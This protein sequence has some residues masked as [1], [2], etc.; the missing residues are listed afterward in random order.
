LKLRNHYKGYEWLIYGLIDRSCIVQ[1]INVSDLV[2]FARTGR[3]RHM[4]DV[5]QYISLQQHAFGLLKNLNMKLPK[6]GTEIGRLVGKVLDHLNIPDRYKALVARK[7]MRMMKFRMLESALRQR[8]YLRGVYGVEITPSDGETDGLDDFLVS[9][10]EEYDSD[11]TY[12][13][14]DDYGFTRRIANRTSIESEDS[15]ENDGDTSWDESDL[16]DEQALLYAQLYAT[17]NEAIRSAPPR[18][19]QMTHVEVPK[20]TERQLAAFKAALESSTK[21]DVVDLTKS[22]NEAE[23]EEDDD[24]IVVD[25]ARTEDDDVIEVTGGRWV[26]VGY[27]QDVIEVSATQRAKS[28]ELPVRST[29]ARTTT[30]PRGLARLEMDVEVMEIMKFD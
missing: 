22:G 7:I 11:A 27:E 12:W 1:T 16:D 6:T 23:A 21:I 15:E 14:D 5:L 3:I 19:L 10:N 20:L 4:R 29:S 2:D 25:E 26:T 18:M 30:G 28:F 9:S 13:D 17:L 24:V 8:A